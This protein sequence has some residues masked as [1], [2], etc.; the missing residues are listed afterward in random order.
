MTFGA[1]KPR[2]HVERHGADHPARQRTVL[3][4]GAIALPR[5]SV[6]TGRVTDDNGE[7]LARVQVYTLFYPPGSP[8][9]VRSGG[10]DST[11]DLGQFR[12]YGLTPGDYTVVAEAR[13]NTF[14]QPNAAPETEED[15]I[16]FMT[17][18]YPGTPDE[19][20]AQRVR[21]PAG[22]ETPGIEIRVVSGRLFR[23][24]GI[25]TDSK[26]SPGR[27]NGTLWKRTS[28]GNQSNYGFST[29]EQGKF[30]M[31]NIPPGT[32]RLMIRQNQAGPR[33]P[34]GSPVDPGEFANVPLT[35]NGDL[36][37]LMI[38][39][40]P[41]ATITGHIVYEH[42]PPQQQAN[43]TSAPVIRINAQAGDPM[44]NMG[45]QM[46]QP[47]VVG[48]DLTFTMKG[49]MGE[50]L[51]R[52]N[53]PMQYLK[54]VTVNGTDVTDTPREFKS[55]DKVTI[56]MSSRASTVE[57][58]VTDAAGTAVT[59]AGLLLFADDKASWRSNSIRTRRASVDPTGH[60]KMSGLLPGRYFIIA[61]PRE[62]LNVMG[63]MDAAMFEDLSKEATTLVVG[64]DEQR[65]VDLKV[66]A[67]PG[68][69]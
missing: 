25:V 68:G 22:G 24:S 26:G 7:P 50:M 52:S 36:E 21:V 17:S 34:D 48:Q 13:P 58:N 69:N 31:K 40:T 45:M 39:T 15:R 67:N 38:L 63:M 29:D 16:G 27:V 35:I 28:S 43:Q 6:V 42:G 56:T 3:R 47:A 19:Q 12:V 18:Y 51:L 64:D 46:P 49:L 8:R 57:G 32:Y 5:G 54:S 37:D 1:K 10:N 66:V 14:V 33:N 53:A 20:S 2:A 55:G 9:G 44:D 23:L 65:Q 60:F 11:D 4:E 62:R 61:V 30:Q 41:G 59:D